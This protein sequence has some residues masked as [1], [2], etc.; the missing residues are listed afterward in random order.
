MSSQQDSIRSTLKVLG[1]LSICAGVLLIVFG[2][3]NQSDWEKERDE[4]WKRESREFMA[5]RRDI[6]DMHTDTG[7]PVGFF[8]S[9]AGMFA[10]VIGL[11]LLGFAYQK[12]VARYQ[13]REYAPVLKEAMREIAPGL[14]GGPVQTCTHCRTENVTDA[15]FCKQCGA[16]LVPA[17]CPGC[18]ATSEPGSKFCTSCG[19][20]L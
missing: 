8:M 14:A 9:G 11:A 20:A 17:A 2:C 1:P 19:R 13:M 5:G 16:P 7:F 18:G 4:R 12:A 15:R 3:Q 6:H 10:I